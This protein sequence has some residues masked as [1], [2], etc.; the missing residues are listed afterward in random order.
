MWLNLLSI[1]EAYKKTFDDLY[2]TDTI[3]DIEPEIVENYDKNNFKE[4][5][6]GQYVDLE[7]NTILDNSEFLNSS[8][9]G[10]DHLTYII[11][12]WLIK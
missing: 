3:E 10:K 12:K 11:K 9:R 2:G 6:D 5:L 7:S 1:E 8:S 4:L